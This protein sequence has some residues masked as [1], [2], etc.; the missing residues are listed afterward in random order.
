M[1]KPMM[2]ADCGTVGKPKR[3]MKGSILI[4]LFL[5]CMILLPGLIYSIWRF[6]TVGKACRSCNSRNLIQPGSPRGLMLAQ[7]L[8]AAHAGKES[9]PLA[10]ATQ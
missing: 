9:Y 4:E 3:D 10:R 1:A 8:A 5:W 2:C 7:Q 6:T